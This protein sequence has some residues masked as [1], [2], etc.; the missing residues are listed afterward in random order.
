MTN[1][2]LKLL[3]LASPGA[4]SRYIIANNLV[5]QGPFMGKFTIVAARRKNMEF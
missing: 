3:A 1:G 5:A 2:E 4:S